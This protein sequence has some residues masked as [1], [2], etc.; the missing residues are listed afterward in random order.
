[1]VK[2]FKYIQVAHE[3]AAL[4]SKKQEAYG[5]SFGQAGKLMRVIYPAGIMPGQMDDALTVVR[6][7]DKLFRIANKKDA[8]NESPWRDIVGYGL[9][10]VVRDE[11]VLNGKEKSS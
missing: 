1:M 10:S 3:V 5:D 4:V 2:E 9:L 11:E 6:I 8:F 7:L